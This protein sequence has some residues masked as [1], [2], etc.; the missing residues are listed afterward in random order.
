L[1]WRESPWRYGLGAGSVREVFKVAHGFGVRFL[2]AELLNDLHLARG[3]TQPN[4][5]A[6]PQRKGVA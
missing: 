3:V 1:R 6:R 4:G 5:H 2:P